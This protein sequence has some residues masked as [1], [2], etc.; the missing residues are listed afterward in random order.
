MC[1]RDELCSFVNLVLCR[2]TN[3][4]RPYI[5]LYIAPILPRFCLSLRMWTPPPTINF[6]GYLYM[7]KYL[8]LVISGLLFAVPFFI[9]Q[10]H[11]LSFVSAVPFFYI[12]FKNPAK[13]IKYSVC[14]GMSFYLAVYT[15]FLRMYPMEQVGVT[16]AESL[17]IVIA[18]WVGVSVIQMFVFMI[19]PVGLKLIRVKNIFIMP[20]LA[21]SLYVILEWVQSWFLSGLTWGKLAV[22][23]YRDLFFIQ[24]MSVFGTYFPA[25]I[26]IFINAAIA[27]YILHR[28]NNNA[29]VKL[30]FACIIIYFAN[31]CF[32]FFR[33][34]LY[35][36]DYEKITAQIVQGNVSSYEKWEDY[37]IIDQFNIHKDLTERYITPETDIS[38]WAETV[39]P[40]V[41]HH[42]GGWY[43]AL[44][45]IAADNNITLFAGAFHSEIIS[46]ESKNFNAIMA[47]DTNYEFI[48]PYA[49]RQLVPF[50]EFLPFEGI[51]T[52]L[53]PFI[54]NINLFNARLTPGES[55]RLMQING[56]NYG[57]LVCFDSIFPRLARQSVRDG[58]DI[59]LISTNDSWFRDS[60]AIY[61]HN[62]QAVLRAVQNNR[63]V[64]RSANTGIS[65][66]ISSTGRVLQQ[67]EVFE[68][69]AMTREVGLVSGMTIYTRFGEIILYLA[70]IYI[71]ACI[72]VMCSRRLK[73]DKSDF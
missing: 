11:L 52:S 66:F 31:S 25:F 67:T 18:A 22:S 28:K 24:S 70:F 57:G 39:V 64:V 7:K 4:V 49:K 33:L 8:V 41:I 48:R 34:Y 45:N 13:I 42:G 50:G 59:L 19:L 71:I 61:Q 63:Y 16:P 1:C 21:A 65:S 6:T 47:F 29:A 30:T 58:A 43:N 3:T 5:V 40:T 36:H 38:L 62:A 72:A 55:S 20:V 56:V 44:R 68:R 26:I 10:L 35:N 60:M 53:F 23:Q 2:R 37:S 69:T 17:I 73:S 32:G 12:I 46:G 54:D 27:L 15:W 51:L 9:P 14:F